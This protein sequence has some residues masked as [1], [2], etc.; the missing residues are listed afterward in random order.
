MTAPD[1]FPAARPGGVCTALCCAPT[2]PPARGG[3]PGDLDDAA[4][5]D[6]ARRM[7]LTRRIRRLVT[8]TIACNVMEAVIAV[9]AGGAASSAALIAFGLDSLIEVA[10]AVAVAWQF[11]AP[12]PQSRERAALRVIAL[13][14]FALAGYVTFTSVRDLSGSGQAHPSPVGI[15]LAAV[16]LVVMPLLSHLQRRAGRALGS[17]SVVADSHQTLLCTYL[18]AV[19]LVGLLVDALFGWTWADPVTA[20]V[21]AAVAL[22]EGRQV[23]RGQHCCGG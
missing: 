17:I 7:V 2:P 20:L 4:D 12:D 18:S 5:H 6:G 9:I 19:L 3:D 16:S 8:A 10:S 13:S 15:A 11:S 21:I 22:Q 1:P 23:W 14:F